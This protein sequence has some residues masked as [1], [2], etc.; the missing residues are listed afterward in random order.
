MCWD[1]W[2]SICKKMK[3]DP[4]LTLYVQKLIKICIGNLD[5]RAEAIKLLEEN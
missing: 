4:Y 1:S 5:V 3:L 2:I